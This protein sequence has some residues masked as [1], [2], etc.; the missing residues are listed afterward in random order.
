MTG[1]LAVPHSLPD[2]LNGVLL[3]P[4]KAS[5]SPSSWNDGATSPNGQGENESAGP[6]NFKTTVMAKSPVMKSVSISSYMLSLFKC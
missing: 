2:A 3:S 1:T 6:F 4:T 5:F